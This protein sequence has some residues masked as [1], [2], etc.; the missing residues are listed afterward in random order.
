[1][2]AKDPTMR[3]STRDILDMPFIEEYIKE[4]NG[5]SGQFDR[6]KATAVVVHEK[7]KSLTPRDKFLKR[8]EEAVL[9]KIRVMNEAV[10][11]A[12]NDR[13]M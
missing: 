2:L 5:A 13:A 6:L 11:N 1:M 12:G 9:S 7:R 4:S 8:K 3:P 10:K